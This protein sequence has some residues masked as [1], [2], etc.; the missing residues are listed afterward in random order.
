MSFSAEEYPV[1]DVDVLRI[2][3]AKCLNLLTF[4]KSRRCRRSSSRLRFDVARLRV[5]AALGRMLS[6]HTGNSPLHIGSVLGLGHDRLM[7]SLA[8]TSSKFEQSAGVALAV[9]GS[10]WC[11]RASCDGRR[12]QEN[13]P[14]IT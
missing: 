5:V 6:L 9:A 10:D 12:R 2:P 1:S 11:V 14:R 3:H 8:T 4:G 13:P 7:T